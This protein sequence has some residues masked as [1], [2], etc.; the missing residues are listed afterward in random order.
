[1][2]TACPLDCPDTCSLTVGVAEGR[3][4]S[5]DAGPASSTTAGFI[6]AKVRR[7]PDHL[8]GAD[9]LQ[10]PEIRDGVRGLGKFRRASWD[11]AMAL[12]ADKL[13]AARDL[14]GGESI[15]PY[16][17]GGSNGLLTH[18]A[19]DAELF[20]ALGASRLARTVCAAPTGLG[21]MAM[22]GKMP[23]VAYEDYAHAKLIVVWG[24]NPS[25]SG[26]H[27][28][29]FLKDAREAGATL[30]VVDPRATP[31][32]RQANLHLAVRPGTDLVLAL[33]VARQLFEAGHV[34]TAFLD[35]HASGV[36][37]FRERAEPWTLDRV[38]AITGIPEA[39]IAYFI[40]LYAGVRPSVLRCGWGLERNRNGTEA[41][42]AVL[43]LPALVNAFGVRGGGYTMSNSAAW[44]LDD[45]Q[46]RRVPQTSTRTINMNRL[47][48]VLVGPSTPPVKVLFVYN[49]NPVATSPDQNRI[50]EGLMRED[51]F[52][53]VFDQVRTDTTRYADVILPATTFLEHYDIARGYG[54][55]TMQLVRPVIEPVGESRNNTEVFSE[56]ATRLGLGEAEDDTDTLLRV[57][58]RL[59]PAIGT[60]L[61]ET[62]LP[63]PPDGARPI[64]MI[65]THPRTPD[66]RIHLY[67]AS[68]AAAGPLYAYVADPAS[69]T[70]P[71]ALISP[72]SEKTISSTFGQL[73]RRKARLLIHPDDAEPR[74]VI[75]GEPVR[76]Y[77]A[78]GD[79]H[80]MAQVTS[81]I[82]RGVVSLPKG[83]WR[84]S[85]LNGETANAL[86]PATLERHS[87]GACFNDARVEVAR[88]VTAAVGDAEVALYLPKPVP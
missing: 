67:P 52:T 75:D 31:L 53:V 79:V 55:Y 60:A 41:V 30:V 80:C 27:L 84:H 9:R 59:P 69:P 49:S 16:S 11:D 17:Y 44:G 19:V 32:A 78:I 68:L 66:A 81:R 1:M 35:A 64:Q 37:A 29:P 33:G 3:V 43:A 76:V 24:A 12:I 45:E 18:Q 39:Q 87:G 2:E 73:R 70:Y 47:G 61:M 58:A 38:A 28:V 51:L 71:L 54:N 21:A 13:Q 7:F 22:Y 23:G 62:G 74:G 65:D 56:L 40:D 34:D 82:A 88:I 50:A 25:A 77:N 83:L 14:H 26:I 57:A 10:Y 4:V 72:A 42:L 8:Y 36:E 85:T 86:A 6:C 20:R 63:V 15:L 46:W 48:D 5:V